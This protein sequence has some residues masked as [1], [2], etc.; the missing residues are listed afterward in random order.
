MFNTCKDKCNHIWTGSPN[1]FEFLWNNPGTKS[2]MKM[3]EGTTNLRQVMKAPRAVC[4]SY[5]FLSNKG[6]QNLVA[7]DTSKHHLTVSVTVWEQLHPVVLAYRLWCGFRP[8]VRGTA[9][10][11]ASEVAPHVVCRSPYCWLEASGQHH[12]ACSQV[13][14]VTSQHGSSLPQI[15]GSKTEP[16]ASCSSFMI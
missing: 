1:V 3:A 4:I 12:W 2:L 8:G 9:A 15:K 16:G 10:G 11:P 7:S 13:T 14:W 6:P 5:R